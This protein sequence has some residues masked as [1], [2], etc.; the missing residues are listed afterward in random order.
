MGKLK[1]KNTTITLRQLTEEGLKNSSANIVPKNSIIL[2][3]RAPIGHL[4]VNTVPMAFNQGCKA[5]VPF[6]DIINTYYLYY[7]LL[8]SKKLLNDLGSGTTFKEIS[9]KKLS[10]VKLNVP[11]LEVQKKIVSKLDF[12]FKN[13]E[14]L[15]DMNKKQIDNYTKL[16]EA[17]LHNQLTL[18][19]A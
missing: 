3:C 13:L 12:I 6:P 10:S 2:S 17:L 18:E 8:S 16:K 9:S 7:F 11:S 19:A 1:D 15:K 14:N 5:L 4:A